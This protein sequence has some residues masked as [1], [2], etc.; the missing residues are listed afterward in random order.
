LQGTENRGWAISETETPRA[1]Q[2]AVES[3][4]HQHIRRSLTNGNET[5]APFWDKQGFF[6]GGL[7]EL[8]C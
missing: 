5:G 1:E 3:E 2:S 4:V 8:T 6:V 7:G